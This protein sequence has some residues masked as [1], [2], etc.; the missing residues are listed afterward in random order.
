MGVGVPP[1]PVG[2]GEGGPGGVPRR[3]HPRG[4]AGGELP[5]AVAGLNIED[6]RQQRAA[7]GP[8]EQLHRRRQQRPAQDG[9]QTRPAGVPG[10]GL[11]EQLPERIRLAEP[12]RGRRGEQRHR[13]G[14]VVGPVEG[15]RDRRRPQEPPEL[16]VGLQP[17][18]KLEQLRPLLP[19]QGVL[20][21]RPQPVQPDLVLVF[22]IVAVATDKLL[23]HGYTVLARLA[24]SGLTSTR[25][26]QPVGWSGAGRH[27]GWSG[28]RRWWRW[29]R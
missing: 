27:R 14:G 8:E 26:T 6:Q 17:W 19:R 20:A 13:V 2:P 25:P 10:E 7:V 23:S 16:P 1:R 4:Q 24:R 9:D 11:G 12:R 29:R 18:P 15:D 21:C 28:G 5:A 22:V 3:P